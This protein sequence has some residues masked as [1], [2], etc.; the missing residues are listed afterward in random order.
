MI[1]RSEAA[2]QKLFDAV[3]GAQPAHDDEPTRQLHPADRG[4]HHGQREAWV[5]S[6][7]EDHQPG[8]V[9]AGQDGGGHPHQADEQC[10]PGAED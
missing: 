4:G 10:L 9:G 8:G 7:A 1:K 6:G 5:L 2:G 3:H